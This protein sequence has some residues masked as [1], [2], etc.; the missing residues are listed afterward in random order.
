MSNLQKR[1]REVT[2]MFIQAKGGKE[3][4]VDNTRAHEAADALDA[5]DV[6]LENLERIHAATV[7]QMMLHSRDYLEWK[8][9]KD[10]EIARLEAQVEYMSGFLAVVE[11]ARN[12]L[13][14]IDDDSDLCKA[15]KELDE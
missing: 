7:Q 15:L 10:V 5:K 11:A 8:D 3:Q 12:E 13:A 2:R 9:A 4:Q 1:L 6:E 14:G